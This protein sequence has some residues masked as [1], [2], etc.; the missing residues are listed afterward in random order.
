[1]GR[2]GKRGTYSG[3]GMKGQLSR[4]GRRLVPAIR[5]VIK[6]YPK[7]RGYRFNPS[8]QKPIVLTIEVLENKFNAADTVNPQTLLK[9]GLIRKIKGKVPQ[10]KILGEAKVTKKL[11]V[12][13]CFLSEKAKASIEK[14]G[15]TVKPYA[16]AK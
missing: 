3:A 12:E 7:L 11:I 6:R 8:K 5:H 9:Q 14:A 15:G 4:S 2:G 13:G 10:V 16:V 1:M